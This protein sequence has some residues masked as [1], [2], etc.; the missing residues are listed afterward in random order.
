[1]TLSMSNYYCDRCGGKLFNGNC[2][3]CLNNSNA[4]REFE[5]EDE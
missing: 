5:E 3:F 1:M 4:L 2:G